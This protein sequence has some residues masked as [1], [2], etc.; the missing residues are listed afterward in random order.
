MKEE[1]NLQVGDV[2]RVKEGVVCP[3]QKEISIAGWQ[4]RVG[5]VAEEAGKTFIGIIWDSITINNLPGSYIDDCVENNLDEQVLY[6]EADDV[7]PAEPRDKEEDV[8]K[9]T[10]NVYKKSKYSKYEVIIGG[11]KGR[12]IAAV[13]DGVNEKNRIDALKL[14]KD[15][16]NKK[17]VFPFK[18]RL[19]VGSDGYNLQ[20]GDVVVVKGTDIL[21]ET[22]GIIVA[23]SGGY[24]PLSDLEPTKEDDDI[25]QPVDDYWSWYNVDY[26]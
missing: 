13:M 3:D 11:E 16:L 9:A 10:R 18:A 2:V 17:A 5:S 25:P 26:L 23:V 1:K 14:W 7:E 21:D 20:S 22:Y 4:G 6:L 12:R 15:Y 19:E 24:V 8:W